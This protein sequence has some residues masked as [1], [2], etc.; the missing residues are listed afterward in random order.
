VF[1]IAVVPRPQSVWWA[2]VPDR[3]T[4][5]G[6]R[7]ATGRL[8]EDPEHPVYLG[9]RPLHD[10]MPGCQGNEKARTFYLCA[11]CAPPADERDT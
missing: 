6:L 11:I 8:C 7:Y 4:I 3:N 2:K 9:I 10:T 5:T 1:P